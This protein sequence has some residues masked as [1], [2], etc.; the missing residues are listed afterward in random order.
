MGEVYDFSRGK[1]L[2]LDS[3]TSGDYKPSIAYGHLYTKYSEVIT[4][5]SSSSND[6]GVLSKS[7]DILFPGSS[8]VPNGTAQANAIMLDNIQLGGDVIIA[9]EKYTNSSFAPFT[10]YQI[11][12]QRT[13]LFPITVGTTITHMYGKDLAKLEFGF[14]TIYE[15]TQIGSFF[16]SL[17]DLI[18]LHQRTL[19]FNYFI[20]ILI[21]I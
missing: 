10:S 8:T 19:Y 15:Q 12:S 16:Q 18:T 17:D 20:L 5:V 1:G 7:N 3:F 11:N 21:T 9:R 4:N 14:P 2:P 13:K 6:E